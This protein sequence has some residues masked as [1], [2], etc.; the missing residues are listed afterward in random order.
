MVPLLF[1]KNAV[2]VNSYLDTITLRLLPQWEEYSN[3]FIFHQDGV[4]PH[5]DKAIQNHLNA[6]LP[7]RWIGHAI[8]NHVMWRRRTP[9]SPDSVMCDFL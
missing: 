3:D 7:Q 4:A 1:V 8:D 6:Q 2:T 5:F 9:G